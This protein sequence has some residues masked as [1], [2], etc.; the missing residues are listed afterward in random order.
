M[1]DSKS[2]ICLL[3]DG[4]CDFMSTIFLVLATLKHYVC[5]NRRCLCFWLLLPY[6]C[7]SVQSQKETDILDGPTAEK[8]KKSVWKEN[9]KTE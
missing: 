4:A 6:W 9:K 7:L 2:S 5:K 8:L 1:N 3:Q